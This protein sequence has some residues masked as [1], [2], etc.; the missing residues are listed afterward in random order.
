MTDSHRGEPGT[1][2]RHTAP[3]P[4][5]AS[6]G[7]AAGESG[8]HLVVVENYSVLHEGA[9]APSLGP[10][11]LRIA[12]GERVL[13]LG[14]SG[15]GKSTLLAALAGVLT[16]ESADDGV[17]E[18]GIIRLRGAHPSEARGTAGLMHQDPE[19]QVVMA[20]VG[21]DVAFGPEN[22]GVDPA[23]I[24]RRIPASLEAVGLAGMDPD[25]STGR[26][27]G[28]QKQR[29]GL[30]GLLAME[31]EL[32]LLDE[33]TANLDPE[34]ARDVVAAVD[35]VCRE[36]GSALV[37][38]EHRL[39]DWARM[40]ERAVV[41][42]PGGGILADGPVAEVLA[43]DSP[44]RPVL[45]KAGV[46]LPGETPDV[47]PRSGAA[48][49]GADVVLRTVDLS[50]TRDPKRRWS[51]RRGESGRR[52]IQAG[53]NLEV[54]RGE[55]LAIMGENGAG[56]ST[57]ALTLAGL[58]EPLAGRVEA[59]MGPGRPG[60]AGNPGHRQTPGSTARSEPFHWRASD[61]IRRI[62]TV[63]QNPEHQFVTSTVAGELE[64]GPRLAGMPEEEVAS[65]R[66]RLLAQLG[67][68]DRAEQQPF[69]LSGGQKRRLS[70]ASALA[71]APGLLIVDEPT[72]GQ[73]A[74][75]WAELAGLFNALLD[76]GVAVI[77]VTHDAAFADAIG[78][79]VLR[80]AATA[81]AP[82]GGRP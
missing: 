55:A 15:S 31:P 70:V 64:H 71:A 46:W 79:R 60:T 51:I 24:R 33:P 35:A 2:G 21:R 77:A 49:Q 75:T 26:L 81:D 78:A 9:P 4:P 80:L 54:R 17:Q 22:L 48:V 3:A 73:D 56:K 28:G 43:E 19:S 69:T 82:Q 52:A 41:L 34:G 47:R 76:E 25:R 67:L 8:G 18:S 5:P 42:A 59:G 23:E 61:L 37:V 65:I 66:D 45:R 29:V 40:T 12:P 44:M 10:V 72:F 27:S 14:P 1:S 74:R 11:T 20:T 53:L 68:E 36:R 58:L 13:L 62:G 38:V 63:F 57:L 7:G 6:S 16:S 39:E 32:L 50:V 30:A